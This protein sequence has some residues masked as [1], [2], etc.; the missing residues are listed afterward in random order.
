MYTVQAKNIDNDFGRYLP[1]Q[2]HTESKEWKYVVS[3][4]SLVNKALLLNNSKSGTLK[5]NLSLNEQ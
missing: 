5:L 2:L 3:K 4:Y 1:L